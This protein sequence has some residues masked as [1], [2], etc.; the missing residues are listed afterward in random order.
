MTDPTPPPSTTDTH[1]VVADS[2]FAVV[3]SWLLD[4]APSGAVHLYAVL[5]RY[6]DNQTGQAWPS[7]AKLA[8]RLGCSTDTVDRALK[9][10]VA[11]GALTI[12]HRWTPAGD[13]TTSMYHLHV[14]P[15]GVAAPVRLGSRKDAAGV[16]APV[17]H[18]TR[19]IELEEPPTPA[20]GAAGARPTRAHHGQHT[21][22]RACG[23][24]PR[25]LAAVDKQPRAR[26]P[27]CGVCDETD[28]TIE[29]P[30]ATVRRCPD[31]HP[32]T[33]QEPTP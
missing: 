8:K 26:P 15:A 4:V 32:L 1:V 2:T 25:Q 17:R 19:T 22:C 20:A 5:A 10:L 23:T 13:P 12:T 24:S 29:L 28:R 33:Q 14:M 31:C 9:A 21:G 27:W 18:R 7:R 3:P 11:A 30:G 16:A 6:A